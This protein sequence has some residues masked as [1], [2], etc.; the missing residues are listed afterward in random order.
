[1]SNSSTRLRALKDRRVDGIDGETLFRWNR[2]EGKDME[3]IEGAAETR[4]ME[5]PKE[6]NTRRSVL[7]YHWFQGILAGVGC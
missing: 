1:M 7:Y 3:G 4:R 5:D 2:E 6:R